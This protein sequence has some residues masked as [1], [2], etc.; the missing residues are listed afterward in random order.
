MT[1]AG[2]APLETSLRTLCADALREAAT[3]PGTGMSARCDEALRRACTPA[4]RALALETL[5]AIGERHGWLREARA[6]LERLAVDSPR[7]RADLARLLARGWSFATALDALG[8][9]SDEPLLRAD[10]LNAAGRVDDA[11]AALRAAPEGADLDARL[12][13]LG[14]EDLAAARAPNGLTAARV[15]LWRGDLD[16]AMTRA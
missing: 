8:P 6:A 3:G 1:R 10:L 5:V 14:R 16:H 2:D 9:G 11:L 7:R 12:A 4:E 15:A 13:A